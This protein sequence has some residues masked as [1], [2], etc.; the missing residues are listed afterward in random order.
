MVFNFL[1]SGTVMN[2]FY[3]ILIAAGIFLIA[4]GVSFLYKIYKSRQRVIAIE[5]EINAGRYQ[6]ALDLSTEFFKEK[7]SFIAY[8]YIARSCEGLK[9]YSKAIK[10]YE[11]AI[12]YFSGEIKKSMKAEVLIRIGDMYNHNKDYVMASGNYMLA[13]QENPAAIRA[14]YQLS[15]IYYNSKNYQKAISNLE[16]LAIIKTDFWEALSLLGKA[17]NEIGGYRKAAYYFESAL[18][19]SINDNLERNNINFRLAEVYSNLKN[20]KASINILKPLLNNNDYFEESLLKIL[21]NL[22]LDNQIKETIK[23]SMTYMDKLSNKYKDQCLYILGRA[24]FDQGEYL[25]AIDA[26]VKAFQINP[27]YADLR[28]LMTKYKILLDNPLLEDYYSKEESI[29]NDFIFNYLRLHI[30]QII[31]SEKSFKIFRESN[32]KMHIFFRNPFAMNSSDLKQT[33]EALLHEYTSNMVCL[34]YT[35]FGTTQDCKDNGFYKQVQ[36]ISG[37]QFVMVFLKKINK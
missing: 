34:L 6:S 23:I 24:Y 32:S 7:R 13:L 15:F 20:Y 17:Y 9:D 27:D 5:D 19:L 30:S 22:I 3:L 12:N 10:Y 29:F 11:D 18:K 25:S 35:L 1:V 21:K 2:I 8:Y 16:K 14:L 36:E 33:E 4:L 28:E 37:D 26:W 31:S